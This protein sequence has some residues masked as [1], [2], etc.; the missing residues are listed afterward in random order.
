MSWQR[1]WKG[2]MLAGCAIAAA[3]A[4]GGDGDDGSIAE[5]AP[6]VIG[7]RL[8]AGL[9]SPGD[10]EFLHRPFSLDML[11][12]TIV[13]ADTR[14]HRIVLLDRDLRFLTSFGREGAGPGEFDGPTALAVTPGGIVVAEMQNARFTVLDRAGRFVHTLGPAPAIHSF[15]VASDGAL[16]VPDESE[17]HFAQRLTAERGMPFAPRPAGVQPRRLPLLA[18]TAGDTVHIFEERS[19]TLYKF[20]PGGDTV[21]SRRLPR[22]L[23]D[24]L[25]AHRAGVSQQ[26]G[27]DDL[28]AGPLLK[29]MHVTEGGALLLV[30]TNGRTVALLVDPVSY[31]G[32]RLVV[33]RTTGEWEPLPS[34]RDIELYGDRLFALSGESPWAFALERNGAAR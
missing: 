17:T 12:D 6:L 28:A 20:S 15:G 3:C 9:Q 13:I 27:G 10:V 23:F 19:G 11:G 22:T 32:R 14:N 2:V 8:A 30:L 18:V 7:A 25:D 34:A 4:G 16:L 29:A 26:F 21:M 1:A 31:R 5:D 24:S 33:P